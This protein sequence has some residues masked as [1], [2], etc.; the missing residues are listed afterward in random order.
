MCLEVV[1]DYLRSLPQ[2]RLPHP[3]PSF[4]LYSGTVWLNHGP[5]F[6]IRFSQTADSCSSIRF[7]YIVGADDSHNE[8]DK[9]IVEPSWTNKYKFVANEE[10]STTDSENET[11]VRVLIW[12]S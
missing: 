10:P 5:S 4:S 8:E 11:V 6:E 7:G 9:E 1:E 2:V 12:I 3:P